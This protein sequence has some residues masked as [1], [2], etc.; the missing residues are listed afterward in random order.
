MCVLAPVYS[1]RQSI[2][3]GYIP[4]CGR[5]S[6]DHTGGERHTQE[7]EVYTYNLKYMCTCVYL[8]HVVEREAGVGA[9]PSSERG[10][11]VGVAL[12]EVR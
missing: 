4:V 11:H 5:I 7:F 12:A 6:R 10:R 9:E 8:P 2:T 3:L 1:G